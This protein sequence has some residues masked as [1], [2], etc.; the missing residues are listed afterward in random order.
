MSDPF[1]ESQLHLNRRHFFGKSAK[2]VG[3]AAL[4]NLLG[5]DLLATGGVKIPDQFRTTA[6]KAKRMIYLFQS[7]APSQQELFDNKPQ[8]DKY[9]GQE[10]SDHVEMNQRVTGMTAGQKSFP[11]AASKYQFAK[12]G[13]AGTEISELLPH[14][15]GISD[16]ICVIRSMYTEAI[17]HDPAITFFQTGSQIPGR[18]SIGSWMSYGLGSSNKD[19]PDFVAMVSRGTGRPNCQPLYDRLWGSGFLPTQHAGV[20]F[21]S[22][23]DPVLYLSNPKG[24]PARSRRRMLDDLAE[25][26]EK[27]L[28]EFADPEIATRIKQYEL[29]YRMQ[30]SVPELTDFSNEPES[31]LQM[32]GPNVRKR[33]TYAYNCLMARRLAERDVRFVQLFHMGWDQ[34]F[35]LPKQLPGQ[36]EDVDQPT[37]A[38]IKDLKMRGLLED[39]LVVWGGEFGRTA[40]CQGTLKRDNYG[41]DHHPRCFSIFAAGGGVKPGMT[42]GATDDYS[43]NITEN[44]VHVHDLHATILHQMGIDHERLTY[45]FQGRQ[46]RLTDVHG[47]IVKDILA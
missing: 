41:R 31:V 19:L 10:L 9:F 28:S 30:T 22:T 45:R 18:P 38:L 47:H 26:N 24:F 40:Y 33:G 39:T 21:M 2:G 34:H 1:S 25:L 29:A 17:N 3:V 36:C 12:H 11:L 35:T 5:Q 13:Q 6:P 15:A 37:A 46:F 44:P 8:L 32:Y 42:Y 23:G 16:D 20:K 14:I 7:G 43:Y 27:K 4:A